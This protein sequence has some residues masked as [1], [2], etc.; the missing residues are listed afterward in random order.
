MKESKVLHL[1][2]LDKFISPLIDL[3]ES[4]EYF[5]EHLFHI[6]GDELKFPVKRR[7]NTTFLK[8]YSNKFSA[9]LDLLKVL[10]KTEKIIIHGLIDIKI[11]VLLFFQPWLLKK[12]Y[13]VMWGGD[14]YAYQLAERNWKWRFKEFFRRPVIKHMGHL[15]TYI[16]GDVALARKW[17]GATGQYHECIMYT[18]NVYREYPVP[19][20]PHNRINI[21]IGNSADPSNN[22]LEILEQLLPLRDQNIAIYAPLSYGNQEYAQSII[23]AGVEQF[24]EKFKPMT[25]FMPFDQYLEFLG[26]VDIAIF[27]H[28]RQQAMGNTITLLGLGKKVYLRDDVTPWKVF[29]K[30][31]AKVYSTSN[32]NLTPLDLETMNHNQS[33]IKEHFSEKTLLAQLRNIFKE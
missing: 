17:Y 32:I 16:E 12:C 20:E 8:D 3:L 5:N 6:S 26:K 7:G 31:G 21:Q 4:Q 29:E 30:I 24:G 25:D 27:N 13:W 10:N 22:H 19:G 15:V 11:V 28:K 33:I 2:T 9:Y 23:K 14:L 18:S 1:I